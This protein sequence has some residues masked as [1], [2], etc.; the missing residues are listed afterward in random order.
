MEQWFCNLVKQA[1]CTPL[2]MVSAVFSIIAILL[3]W[4]I[5]HRI[6]IN[7][8]YAELVHEYRSTEIGTAIWAIL[9]FFVHDCQNDVSNIHSKY[10]DKYEK[11]IVS[12]D[13][14]K[15][16]FSKTLHFQRR[17]LAQFYSDM[18]MLR[19]E[20]RGFRLSK[21]K[22]KDWFTPNEVKLLGIL[23]YM[24]EPA[25]EVFIQAGDVTELPDDDTPMNRWIKR[26]YDE[27][28]EWETI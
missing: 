25:K 26:L 5:P 11:Q 9:H 16:D 13:P 24:A 12:Q 15:I 2:D 27:V 1:K 8:L 28:E 21:R 22:L 19:Y 6:M 7:Q 23:L 4:F 17:L 3:A 18:A 10:I 20:Y 14:E